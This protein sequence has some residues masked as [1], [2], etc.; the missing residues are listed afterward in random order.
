MENNAISSD[1]L[2]KEFEKK[3]AKEEEKKK[4][5]LAL[6]WKTEK[7]KVYTN[8]YW[9]EQELLVELE[10]TRREMSELEEVLDDFKRIK[11][12]LEHVRKETYWKAEIDSQTKYLPGEDS[13]K[14]RQKFFVAREKLEDFRKKQKEE[15][16]SKKKKRV[17]TEEVS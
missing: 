15:S 9:K 5:K 3:E 7:S 6:K 4:G 16:A 1:T 11:G 17:K 13:E 8:L 14:A 2:R 12:S 10:K